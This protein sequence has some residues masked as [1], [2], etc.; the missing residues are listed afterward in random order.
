MRRRRNIIQNG[1]TNCR[2]CDKEEESLGECVGTNKKALVDQWTVR[3]TKTEGKRCLDSNTNEV[4]DDRYTWWQCILFKSDLNRYTIGGYLCLKDGSVVCLMGE[5]IEEKTDGDAVI[6][7]VAD[8]VQFLI[9]EVEA[10]EEE[11]RMIIDNKKLVEWLHGD[12]GT[13]CD[14]R[15]IKNKTGKLNHLFDII[16]VEYR[17][18][19]AFKV[20]EE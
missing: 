17:N 14:Q 5:D 7:G 10:R 12:K 13:S 8:A 9:E 11:V 16:E 3:K 15:F 4:V 20:K 1:E 2:L 6:R 19:G 18:K